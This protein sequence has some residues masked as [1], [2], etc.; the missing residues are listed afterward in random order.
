MSLLEGN[1]ELL[2]MMADPDF[3]ETRAR[4]LLDTVPE[5]D[6]I[7]PGSHGV[8]TTY[9][10]KAVDANNIRMVRLLFEYGADPNYSGDEGGICP[11]RDLQYLWEWQE[12][13]E[14]RLSIVQLFLENGAD[15]LLDPE[16]DGDKLCHWAMIANCDD[17]YGSREFN[18]RYRYYEMLRGA[19]SGT[20]DQRLLEACTAEEIDYRLV[21]ILLQFG[22]NPMGKVKGQNAFGCDNLYA[23]VVEALFQNYETSEDFYRITE[24]FLKFGMD[25]SRPAVPY[26]FDPDLQDDI[27]HP[28]WFFAF[29]ANE[30]VLRTLK[31]LLDHGLKAEDAEECWHHALFD[32]IMCGGELRTKHGVELFE[33]Y[34][35]KLML[36]ASYPH[37]L[38]AD[39]NLR[40]EIWFDCNSYDLTRFRNWN[41][42]RFEIDTSHCERFPE[43][44]KSIVTI[45]EKKSEKPVWRFGVHMTPADVQESDSERKIWEGEP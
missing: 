11:F 43:V 41:D 12:D 28:L 25:V 7:F 18:Y 33:E 15:P 6:G 32:F 17:E 3:D 35:R 37:V 1:A 2:A 20:L 19:L 24:L 39:E 23:S 21:T 38:E 16:H 36:I 14:I 9:M 30:V 31:L 4:E 40:R 10:N 34:I 44:Y 8:K 22:A 27:F 5:I 13:E 45:I 42:Y 26:G 29:P